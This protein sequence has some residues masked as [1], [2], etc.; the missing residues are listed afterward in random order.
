MLLIGMHNSKPE[1][2][3][4]F[5]TR[6]CISKQLTVGY[7]RIQELHWRVGRIAAEIFLD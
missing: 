3:N 5:G 4:L 1:L 7:P 2:L 6:S